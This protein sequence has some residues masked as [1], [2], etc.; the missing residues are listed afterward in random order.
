MEAEHPVISPAAPEPDALAR[1]QRILLRLVALTALGCVAFGFAVDPPGE[2]LRGIGRILTPTDVLITDFV[3]VGGLGGAFAQAGLLTLLACGAYRIT[4]ASVNGSAVGCLYMLLGFALFGKTLLN[5]WPILAGVALYC[6][7]REEPLRD[8]LTTAIFATAL[9]PVFTEIAFN[10]A[11]PRAASVPLGLLIG[12]LIGFVIPVVARQLFRAHNGFSLYNMGFAAGVLGVVVI[13]VL[14]SYGL[15]PQP[16]MAWTSGHDLPLLVLVALMLAGVIAAAL[17]LD[18][19]P[20]QGL[21]ALHRDPGQAPADFLAAHGAGPTLLNMAVVGAI[22]T[23]LVL[24]TGADLNGPVVGGIVSIIGFGACGKHAANI[25]PVMAGVLL[26]ALAKPFGLTDP[27]VVWAALFGTCLAPVAGRF[28][29]HWGLL[30]GFLHVSVGQ[31]TGAFTAGLNL[32]GNGFAAGLVA[33]VLT[34]V[35]LLLSR[36]GRRVRDR[37]QEPVEVPAA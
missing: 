25:V 16:P 4:G 3:D 33:A 2:V 23:L 29:P 32:Y 1:Q 24:L 8:Q 7:F 30:A 15:T 11:L 13:A 5:V 31:V 28:G 21:L 17:V 22:G 18:R 12:V 9:A 34:P 19:R 37:P 20:W 27:G 35:A 26:G 10:S 14:Q 36:R 6:R